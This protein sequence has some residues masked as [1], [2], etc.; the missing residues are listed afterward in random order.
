M[1]LLLLLSTGLSGIGVLISLCLVFAFFGV[2]NKPL[3]ALVQLSNGTAIDIKA[4]KDDERDPTVIKQFVANTM[5][6]MFSWTGF[7]PPQSMEEAANPKPDLGVP[8]PGKT[9][10]KVPTAAWQNSFALSADFQNPFL[11]Q[12]AEMNQKFGALQGQG[13]KIQSFLVIEHLAAP[14]KV[15]SGSWKVGM[16]ATL[17]IIQ[18]GS[19]I[20]QISFNKDVFVRAVHVP[21]IPSGLTASKGQVAIAE[22]NARLRAAGLEIY[23]MREFQ[24]QDLKPAQN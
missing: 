20:N 9:D 22:L 13:Q 16:I 19:V 5:G 7:L 11:R 17:K 12:I 10:G 24:R 21:Q 18:Q 23:A 4:T 3:P 15:D 8:V 14:V 6:S 2:A 1:G